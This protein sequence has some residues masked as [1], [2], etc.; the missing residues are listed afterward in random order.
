MLLLRCIIGVEKKVLLKINKIMNTVKTFGF[1]QVIGFLN[2]GKAI[3]RL[4]WNGEKMFVIKQIPGTV[5]VEDVP[6]IKS[7]PEFAKELLKIRDISSLNYNN[8]MLI[9]NKDGEVN[10][11]LPS[12]SDI[13]ATDWYIVHE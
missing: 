11:W 13:F 5:N 8:Q 7:L 12:S 6:L 9:I 2:E 10:S 4:G 3:A 1:G